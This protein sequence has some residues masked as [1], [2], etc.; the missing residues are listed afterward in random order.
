MHA[1]N[2][3]RTKMLFALTKKQKKKYFRDRWI[4]KMILD[5]LAELDRQR[6]F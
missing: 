3:Y 1:C 6:H 2:K 4:T 5:I